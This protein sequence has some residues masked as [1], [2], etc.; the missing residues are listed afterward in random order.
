MTIQEMHLLFK[1]LTN[2]VGNQ[3]Y[4]SFEPE[5]IDLS[6]NQYIRTFIKQRYGGLNIH[7]TGF[8]DTQKRIDDLRTLVS[9]SSLILNS[10]PINGKPNSVVA[11]LPENYWFSVHEEAVCTVGNCPSKR[12]PIVARTHDE[13][14]DFINNPY[15]MPNKRKCIRVMRGNFIEVFHG[16]NVVINSVIMRYIRKPQEVSL[17]NDIDCDLS[18]QAHEEIVKGA[19][20]F[21]MQLIGDN[22]NRPLTDFTQIQ[23]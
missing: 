20:M 19:A 1:F 7:K 13:Y 6:I 5:E 8:E 14:N 11:D 10:D 9:N 12:I 23:E 16:A 22:R 21:A 17:A 18:E 2:T 4:V 15:Q 3:S